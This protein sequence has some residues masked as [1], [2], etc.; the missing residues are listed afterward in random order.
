MQNTYMQSQIIRNILTHSN[1]NLG[2]NQ[3]VCNTDIEQSKNLVSEH[4]V[5]GLIN[6][7]SDTVNNKK[8]ENSLSNIFF[9]NH[10]E[11]FY[12]LLTSNNFKY[13]IPIKGISLLNLIYSHWDQRRMSD[14]DVYIPTARKETLHK[15]LL[16]ND[17]L[18]LDEI[19]WKA[20]KHK[21]TYVKKN[22]F[23]DVT[24]EI[25]FKLYYHSDYQPTLETQ[26]EKARLS[27]EDELLYLCYH[28]A[29]QHNFIKLCC[30]A[31]W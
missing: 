7:K 11:L 27:K 8:K 3:L 20:N 31:K 16:K 26:C 2:H 6:L 14:I 17:Y 30:S 28:L 15:L 13:V 19:K 5:W 18:P 29:E 21:A 4:G 10:Y 25:H 1:Q 22:N 23:I 24:I 12:K 9:N